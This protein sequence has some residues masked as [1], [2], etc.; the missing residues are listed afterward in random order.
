MTG[1]TLEARHNSKPMMFAK[2]FSGRSASHAT[3]GRELHGKRVNDPTSITQP[4][5]DLGGASSAKTK[6]STFLRPVFP[7]MLY[8]WNE[9]HM[10]F[11]VIVPFDWDMFHH[12]SQTFLVFLSV[13]SVNFFFPKAYFQSFLQTSCGLITSHP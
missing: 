12:L 8:G 4:C 7:A 1:R 9:N 6:P 11:F 3:S 5:P 13:S 10:R 2:N